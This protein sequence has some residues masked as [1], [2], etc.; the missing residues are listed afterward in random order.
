[1]TFEESR[2]W[3]ND[4]NLDKQSPINRHK[5]TDTCKDLCEQEIEYNPSSCRVKLEKHQ[6]MQ[7]FCDRGSYIVYNNNPY[8]LKEMTFHTP[9][10]HTIDGVRCD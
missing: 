7:V 1:M 4:C 6:N 9:S 10:L 3:S 2:S 8:N 5:L